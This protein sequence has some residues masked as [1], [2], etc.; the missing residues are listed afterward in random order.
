MKKGST[1][2]HLYAINKNITMAND[3]KNRSKKKK[4]KKFQTKFCYF[5]KIKNNWIIVFFF[6]R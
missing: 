3:W 5:Y 4:K 6:D 2:F 1:N